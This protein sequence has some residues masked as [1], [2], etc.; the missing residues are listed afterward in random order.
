MTNA[1][2]NQLEVL[3]KDSGQHL[4][5]VAIATSIPKEGL[6]LCKNKMIANANWT[7]IAKKKAPYHYCMRK[8]VNMQ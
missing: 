2:I 6:Q 8:T 1:I 4:S 3:Q 5:A 7:Y